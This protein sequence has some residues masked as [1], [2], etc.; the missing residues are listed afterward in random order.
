MTRIITN[1]G[2]I[3]GADG[4]TSI[5]LAG[6]LSYSWISIWG[7]FIVVLILIPN[8]IYALIKSK[9]DNDKKEIHKDQKNHKKQLNNKADDLLLSKAIRILEQIG[10]YGCMILM[11]FNIGIAEFG[12]PS[13]YAFLMYFVGNIVLILAYWIT[14]MMFFHTETEKKAMALTIIPTCLF[15]LNGITMRHYLLIICAIIFGITHIY[16]TRHDTIKLLD[17]K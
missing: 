7:I 10:R 1:D 6:S 5:F 16:V 17:I 4:P 9:K 11:I 13:V 8:I 2:I 14:W 12:F 15:I 3:G